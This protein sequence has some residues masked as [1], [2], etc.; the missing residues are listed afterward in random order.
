MFDITCQ[1][2]VLPLQKIDLSMKWSIGIKDL[3]EYG[4]SSGVILRD[5]ETRD[6][7]NGLEEVLLYMDE[8]RTL[9]NDDLKALGLEDAELCILKKED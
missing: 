3:P 6:W 7:F 8:N 4:L 1:T 2:Q 9:L 5:P